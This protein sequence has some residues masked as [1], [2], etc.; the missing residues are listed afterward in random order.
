MKA[1]FVKVFPNINK[2]KSISETG[3][4]SRLNFTKVGQKEFVEHDWSNVPRLNL[5]INW[6]ITP[7]SVMKIKPILFHLFEFSPNIQ[8]VINNQLMKFK[9]EHEKKIGN[10]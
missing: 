5:S 2:I 9:N 10:K 1:K 8:S 3:N 7:L 6:P 4:C